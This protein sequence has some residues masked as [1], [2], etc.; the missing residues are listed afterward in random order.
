M[1][2]FSTYGFAV[3]TLILVFSSCSKKD[4]LRIYA[5]DQDSESAF[6]AQ[7]R[8][9]PNETDYLAENTPVLTGN[10]NQEDEFTGWA[11]F[12]SN[13]LYNGSFY[14]DIIFQDSIGNW[15]VAGAETQF[16][17]SADGGENIEVG[18]P[19]LAL[20][21]HRLLL[22]DNGGT[23]WTL[24]R[25]TDANN[26][27][28][29][30][31][32]LCLQDIN[33]LEIRKSQQIVVY[34]GPFTCAGATEDLVLDFTHQGNRLSVVGMPGSGGTTIISIDAVADELVYQYSGQYLHYVRD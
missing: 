26:N 34:E 24:D 32:P 7:I 22:G 12:E 16:N 5:V 17:G 30:N 18:G 2:K 21:H 23:F 25:V 6:G 15:A 29:N 14:L 3:L 10:C 28:S 20:N 1:T 9:Y 4:T 33:R 19:Q 11:Y 27:P 31:V 8:L 13:D